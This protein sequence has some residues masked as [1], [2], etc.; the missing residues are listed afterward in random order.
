M[1]L[2]K[3]IFASL[4]A[5]IS[6]IINLVFK[7]LIQTD[8]I[9][10]AYYAIPIIIACLF[11][12]LRYSILVALA[13]DIIGVLLSPFPFYLFFTISS[14]MWGIVPALLKGK[15]MNLFKL[16]IIVFIT[17]LLATTTNSFAIAFHITKSYKA[18]LIDLPLRLL[19]LI[20]NTIIIALLTEAV[21]EAIKLKD[22]FLTN[23]N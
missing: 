18:M 7:T 21:S 17:H 2:K 22:S 1:D 3:F 12:G 15:R 20:P 13:S 10:T 9:G 11:L 14:L 23:E 8:K 5:T 4:L 19:L 6:V 16:I